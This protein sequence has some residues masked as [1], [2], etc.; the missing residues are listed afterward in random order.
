MTHDVRRAGPRPGFT[1]V[2]LLVVIAIIAVLIGLLLPAVQKVREAA[3]RTRCQNNLR[4]LGL[5]THGYHEKEGRFPYGGKNSSMDPMLWPITS[6]PPGYTG[7]ANEWTSG[8]CNFGFFKDEWSWA[9]WLLPLIE[10]QNLFDLDDAA[11]V[12]AKPV[13]Y[14]V[15]PSLRDFK[16]KA[17]LDYAMNAGT[18]TW[19]GTG[20]MTQK[21][22]APPDAAFNGIA[23]RT[24][25]GKVTFAAVGDGLSQTLLFGEKNVNL[26]AAIAFNSANGGD[27]ESW[28]NP[29]WDEDVLRTG[30]NPP[31]PTTADGRNRTGNDA[32]FG[33]F[34]PGAFVAVLGDGS[35][36]TIR[37]DVDPTHFRRLCQRN[38]GEVIDFTL[39]D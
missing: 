26:S 6:P 29:G 38:D 18:H 24:M 25:A 20:N 10:Q 5:A 1:L 36:R 28:A 30:T 23:A 21:S 37:Y 39:I 14:F 17:R 22:P 2:E 13:T 32:R 15:C 7:S 34:H 4:Q 9:Y 27:N 31:L 8:N 3:T 12:A 35:T 33:S 11:A 16:T 19:G